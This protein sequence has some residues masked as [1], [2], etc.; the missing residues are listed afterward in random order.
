MIIKKDKKEKEEEEEKAKYLR[1]CRRFFLNFA[2]RK[3]KK[4]SFLFHQEREK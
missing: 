2:S 4:V 3:R 1:T